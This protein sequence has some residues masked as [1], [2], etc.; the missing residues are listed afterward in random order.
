MYNQFEDTVRLLEICITMVDG[1]ADNGISVEKFQSKLSSK[2]ERYCFVQLRD[3]CAR[4]TELFDEM[5][6]I[7]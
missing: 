3:R 2:Y 7:R 4:F 1:A 5:D 6:T